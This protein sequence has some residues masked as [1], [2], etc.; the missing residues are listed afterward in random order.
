MSYLAKDKAAAQEAFNQLG[1]D[2]EQ[3]A[4][5]TVGTHQVTKKWAFSE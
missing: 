2:W 3:T 1:D 4:W 5:Q